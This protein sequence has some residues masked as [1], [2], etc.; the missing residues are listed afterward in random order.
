MASEHFCGACSETLDRC[1]CEGNPLSEP[2]ARQAEAQRVAALEERHQALVERVKPLVEWLE[3]E[4][5][6]RHTWDCPVCLGDEENPH[7]S[8]CPLDPA[9]LRELI[10]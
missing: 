9:T 8:A 2:Q 4:E 7:D 5:S 1:A 10:G 6:W 3:K